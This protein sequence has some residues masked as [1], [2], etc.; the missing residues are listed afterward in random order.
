[1]NKSQVKKFRADFE[2]MLTV[3]QKDTGM[4][5]DLG[6]IRF[7]PDGH[8]T[9]KGTASVKGEGNTFVCPYA[10]ALN[11]QIESYGFSK[12]IIGK[13]TKYQG[14]TY[15]LVGLKTKNRKYPF[16][17]ENLD[18]GKTYKMSLSHITQ[19]FKTPTTS[20]AYTS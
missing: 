4:K 16:I 10:I 9:F 18:N 20:P 8:L 6:N 2:A 12:D 17:A 1:M 15:K 14:E 19:M 13:P 7:S 5:I 3:L 11:E